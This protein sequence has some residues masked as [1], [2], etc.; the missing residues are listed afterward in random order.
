VEI[1]G[2]CSGYQFMMKYDCDWSNGEGLFGG[3]EGYD[4]ATERETE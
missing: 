1:E 3:E 2:V 4:G